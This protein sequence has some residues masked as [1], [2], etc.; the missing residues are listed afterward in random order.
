[1]DLRRGKAVAPDVEFRLDGAQQILVPFDLQVRMQ[2]ALKKQAGAAE[3]NRFLDFVEDHL[4]GQDVAFLMAQRPVERAEA[5]ILR[6][7]VRVVD[8]AV[9]DI[10]NDAI[11]MQLPAEGIR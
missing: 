6:A 2:S 10:G 4:A 9:N 5:A 7:E 11:R 8:V 3:I 1:R